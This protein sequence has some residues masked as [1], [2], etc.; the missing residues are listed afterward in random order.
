MI[1]GGT[2]EK[3]V[4]LRSMPT[5]RDKTAMNGAPGKWMSQQEREPNGSWSLG[6]SIYG[7]IGVELLYGN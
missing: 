6:S 7:L 3:T 1:D 2:V 4:E 5:H